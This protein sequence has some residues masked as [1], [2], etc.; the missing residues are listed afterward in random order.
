MF[1]HLSSYIYII[2]FSYLTFL[3]YFC[4]G[5][6]FQKK[7]KLTKENENFYEEIF[8][9]SLKGVIYCS[10]IA[11]T[12]NFFLPL[13]K[14]L[15]TLIFAIIPIALFK[16]FSLIFSKKFIFYSFFISCVSFLFLIYST[17]NR[18]DA[19]L[20]HLPYVSFLNEHK[21]IFGLSNIHFRF[22]H[23]SIIQYLSA[24]NYNILFG[25]NGIVI[26]ISA[27]SSIFFV[28]LINI[29]ISM[30]QKKIYNIK[31]FLYLFF[32][33]FIF[34]KMNRYSSYGNDGITHLY[35]FILIIIIL[36]L[37]INKNFY[38]I[39]LISVFLFLNKNTYVLTLA[40]PL[41]IFFYKRSLKKNY[42][43]YVFSFPSF[44]LIAWLIKNIIISG[45]IIYPIN[46]SCLDGLSWTNQ[47]QYIYEAISG[48]AYAKGWPQ[49]SNKMI[50]MEE[51]I[52][53]FNWIT[54]W[55]KIHFKFI[56]QTISPF[57][58]TILFI[59][60]YIRG[61]EKKNSF[62]E[63]NKI[64]IILKILIIFNIIFF[65]KF[66]LFR[67]GSSYLVSLIVILSIFL[68]TKISLKKTSLVAKIFIILMPLVFFVKQFDRILSLDQYNYI[69]SPWP[70]IFSLTDK[71][72]IKKEIYNKDNLIIYR[73][74]NECGYSK[75]ICTNYNL[76]KKLQFQKYY[77]YSFIN[78]KN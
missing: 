67:Y 10:F 69:N 7:N 32:S 27:I 26:P 36:S 15:N 70:N 38:I 73:A 11:L 37:G 3:N 4:Y 64:K 76:D 1:N 41:I 25:I 40:I 28:S 63:N 42:L 21:I 12:L 20:Y 75:A 39:Y 57:I 72:E 24:F 47:T 13:N 16:N 77:G 5:L 22:G 14:F 6:I 71:I 49:N 66:P 2:L 56:I 65:L 31:F 35:F 74:K 29:I 54:A 45:C 18:P 46:F 59:I 33:L 55:S 30:N 44:L 34:Y 61:N 62:K 78:L 68:I 8:Y 50:S 17:I 9:I 60:F 48:E 53:N 51:F 23:I 43:K 58:L 19:A 52:Q